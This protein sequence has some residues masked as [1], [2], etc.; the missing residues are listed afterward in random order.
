LQTVEKWATRSDAWTPK[1]DEHLA[2]LVLYHIKTG[3][4]QLRAFEDAANR[5]GRTAAACGYRWNGVVR[6]NYRNEI[7][8]SKLDRKKSQKANNPFMDNTSSQ[9]VQVEPANSSDSMKEVIRFLETYDT[10]YQKLLKQMGILEQEKQSLKHRVLDLEAKIGFTPESNNEPLTPQQLEEDSKT[11]FAIME[12]ARK[13][14]GNGVK[15]RF[16]A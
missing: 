14:L 13:L 16:E 4:T 7:E 1:D 2:T 11:L 12:R 9:I 15:S 8:E 10:H 3:S 5:L 6:K